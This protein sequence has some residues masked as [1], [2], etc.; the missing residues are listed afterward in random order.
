MR[1]QGRCV[2]VPVHAALLGA[3]LI[4]LPWR[5]SRRRWVLEDPVQALYH[6]VDSKGSGGLWPGGYNLVAQYPRRVLAPAPGQ[7]LGGAGF[8]AGQQEALMVEGTAAG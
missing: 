6:F 5:V 8:A 7:T 4:S 3:S 1:L 2:C